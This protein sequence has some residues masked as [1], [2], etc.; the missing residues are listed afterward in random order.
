MTSSNVRRVVIRCLACLF[1]LGVWGC[2]G[3]V[4]TQAPA[5]DG[6]IE[7]GPA[8]LR[9]IQRTLRLGTSGDDVALLNAFLTKSGY[10][11]ND[12]LARQ[13]PAWRPIVEDAPRDPRVFDENTLR[14]VEAYQ[15]NSGMPVTGEIDPGVLA[16][17][18][19]RSCGVPDGAPRTDPS[20]KFAI[21]GGWGTREIGWA[22]TNTD[23]DLHIDVARAEIASAF[24]M[25]ANETNLTFEERDANDARTQIIL[26]FTN[27]PGG[28]QGQTFPHPFPNPLVPN[29]TMIAFNPPVDW[30]TGPSGPP[31]SNL[32]NLQSL[33][34]HEIGHAVGLGHATSTSAKM[35]NSAPGDLS[36]FPEDRIAISLL[37]DTW[38][39]ISGNGLASDIAGINET[40]G[41]ISSSLLWAVGIDRFA[42]GNYGVWRWNGETWAWAGLTGVTVAAEPNGLPWV[43][44]GN[45]DMYCRTSRNLNLGTWRSRQTCATHMAVGAD[46]TIWAIQ[47]NGVLVKWVKPEK[48]S[49]NIVATDPPWR[50]VSFLPG[51]TPIMVG[52]APDGTPWAI[53]SNFE[54]FRRGSGIIGGTP[55]QSAWTEVPSDG[56]AID[57]AID[58]AGY[59]YVLGTN[60]VPGTLNF[61][62]W[63]YNEQDC[64]DQAGNRCETLPENDN[65]SPPRRSWIP[66]ADG[67][68]WNLTTAGVAKPIVAL[69]DGRMF[70]TLR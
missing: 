9:S 38:T 44:K 1:A 48:C 12:G 45:G 33:A 25:W 6:V 63:V 39:P 4:D 60:N 28:F 56:R 58:A 40:N 16:R 23:G 47:C 68:G 46:G 57:I 30:T 13:Y 67:V 61:G 55:T 2:G 66:M 70:R 3:E 18:A 43:L 5:T 54:I 8:E 7:V 49:H 29:Q 14:A 34:L 36:L 65:G 50:A 35:H 62:I 59:A 17:F 24:A 69:D 22:L 41:S 51:K 11:P 64:I 31:G 37:Y 53:D 10:F 27:T 42:D 21:N 19:E 52:V 32:L 15:R 20:E 26:V